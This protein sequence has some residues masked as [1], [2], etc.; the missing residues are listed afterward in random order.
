MQDKL[1]K[2]T[3]SLIELVINSVLIVFLLG[4]VFP[5]L[6]RYANGSSI[7]ANDLEALRHSIVGQ[8]SAGNFRAVNPD[9]GALGYGQVMPE[10]VAPWSKAALGYTLTPDEFLARP[11]LQIAILNHKLTEYWQDAIDR[12]D[13]DKEIAVRMVASRWYS[14][15]ADWYNSTTPQFYN[16]TEYPSIQEYTLSILE[17][18]RQH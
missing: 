11:D 13:G 12:S 3:K 18:Y 9:S 15:R 6:L 7:S 14:G 8:E 4:F 2:S 17:K 1:Q 16:G 5:T 10:N